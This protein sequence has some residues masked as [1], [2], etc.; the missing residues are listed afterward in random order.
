MFIARR[1]NELFSE[2]FICEGDKYSVSKYIITASY[3]IHVVVT[4]TDFGWVF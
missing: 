4:V 1:R 3:E 2:V